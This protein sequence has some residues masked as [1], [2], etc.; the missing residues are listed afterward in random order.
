[1]KVSRWRAPLLLVA[2][3]GCH[4]QPMPPTQATPAPQ[5]ES[6]VTESLGRAVYNFRCYYCHGYS[7]NSRTLAA[8]FLM[9][10]PADF[11]RADPERLTEAAIIEVLR[12]G[13][14]GT[15]M[16]PFAS[17][18]PESELMAVAKFVR[19]EFVVRRAENTRY[20]T[21]A[22]G[23]PNHDR[24][25]LAFPFATGEIP[26]SRP[27]ESLTPEQ[28]K[29]RQLYATTCVSCHDRG[30]ATEDDVAWDA[31]P[32]SYPRNNF[33]LADPPKLD[34]MA[35]ASPY[36]KHDRVPL[37]SG[38]SLSE[39]RGQ[40]LFQTNCAFC[41]GADGTGKNWIGQ[42]LEPHPRNLQDAGFMAS[43]TRERLAE[44]IAEGLPGTSMPAWKSVMSRKDIR[45]VV[46]YI[47]RAFHSLPPWQSSRK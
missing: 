5:L 11:T 6:S 40:K 35:S 22:N 10:P 14:P 37:I 16:K 34:A 32:L 2:L 7:G 15:A 41:H 20:H 44:A 42:F 29:G 26:L 33:S 4:T 24:Y 27:W 12:H 25:R 8:T 36:A 17:V 28:A 21:E 31:R 30:A 45:A 39:K 47:G 23:W 43:M 13:R 19:E 18:I 3:A 1:M 9:P 46:D 38:L